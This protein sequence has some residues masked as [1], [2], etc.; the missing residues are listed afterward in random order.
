[1]VKKI[2][3]KGKEQSTGEIYNISGVFK[4]L[5]ELFLK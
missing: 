3:R 5:L 1:M 4:L 2:K